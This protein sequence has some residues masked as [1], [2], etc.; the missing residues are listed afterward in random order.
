MDGLNTGRFLD[1][2]EFSVMHAKGNL[3]DVFDRI[4]YQV[5]DKDTVHLTL[6]SHGPGSRH[7][8]PT[9]IS[10]WVSLVGQTIPW[11]G[12]RINVQ[13]PNL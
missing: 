6:V 7:R 2:P 10:M 4:D 3:E 8:I 12:P 13:N 11:L 9:T 5:S 1:P